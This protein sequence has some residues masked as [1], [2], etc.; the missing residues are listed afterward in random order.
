[1]NGLY[2]GNISVG[3][4]IW[5]PFEKDSDV[6]EVFYSRSVE[7]QPQGAVLIPNGIE[8]NFERDFSPG[9][10][11]KRNKVTVVEIWLGHIHSS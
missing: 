4:C 10:D 2:F 8:S 7:N 1:M 6:P 11:C 3:Q 9:A 5:K